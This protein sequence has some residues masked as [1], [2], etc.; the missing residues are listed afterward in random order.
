MV[1]M[2]YLHVLTQEPGSARYSHSNVY[3]LS[4]SGRELEPVK[5][6]MDRVWSPD[7]IY[8]GRLKRVRTAGVENGVRV[9]L[10]S[11]ELLS[12][13]PDYHGVAVHILTPN[14]I[15]KLDEK[16]G[17]GKAHEAY[18]YKT[19]VGE[20]LDVMVGGFRFKDPLTVRLIEEL[21]KH[22]AGLLRP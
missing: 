15:R 19:A 2:H 10:L 16:G 20:G 1:S 18:P 7:D 6:N 11:R 21:L 5:I 3:V 9:D 14:Q 8:L 13:S 12:L 4:G 17:D 22:E